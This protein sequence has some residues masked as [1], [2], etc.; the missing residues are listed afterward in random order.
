MAKLPSTVVIRYDGTDITNDVMPAGTRFESLNNAAQGSMSMTV[1]DKDQAYDFVT[2]KEITL[3]IDG[4]PM[5]GGYLTRV[6]RK[7]AFPAVDTT[8]VPPGLVKSRLWVLTGVDFNVLFDKRIVRNP[9]DFLHQLPNYTSEDFDGAMIRFMLTASKYFDVD[10]GVFDVTSQVEDTDAYRTYHALTNGS[11]SSGATTVTVDQVDLY[12]AF[13]PFY[14]IIK[15]DPVT[16]GNREIV[17]VTGLTSLTFDIER[18]AMPDWYLGSPTSAVAHGSG[19]WFQHFTPSAWL[20]QGSLLRAQMEDFTQFSGA[21]FYFAPDKVLHHHALE[22]EEAR[23]GFSD[24]PNK[25]A[26]TASP[27]SY[28]GATIGPRSLDAVTDGEILIN[29]AFIWGGSEWSGDG[30]TVF[31]RR[32]NSTSIADH[33]LWQTAEVHFGEDGFKIQAGVDARAKVI[34]EGGAT[35]GGGFNPGLAYNQ[36]QV[37]LSWFAHDVPEISGQHDHLVA[38]Q[39]VHTELQVFAVG[40][41]PLEQILPLRSLAISFPA[42][43]GNSLS[44]VQF[45]GTFGLQIGDPYTLWRYLLRATQLGQANAIPSTV[46]GSNPAPYGSILAAEPTPAPDSSTTVFYLPDG[47]GYIAGTTEVYVQ[48]QRLRRGVDYVESNAIA[49]QLTFAAAPDGS[50]W[51]WVVCRIT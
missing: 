51:L 12:P 7:F 30:Q 1:R 40:G 33:G 44:Y 16:G 42:S 13:F 47:R 14:A 31:A 4:V 45:D 2:G 25:N 27:A 9:D 43:K 6:Q 35:V 20:Q 21:V 49:G 26:I 34:V 24:R 18:A 5:W 10:D 37:S 15:D 41:F 32:Q 48:G 50:T 28:Q 8:T 22:H 38:G 39:L 17:K 19:S 11:I 29:D 23:W 46:D 3:E 36:W